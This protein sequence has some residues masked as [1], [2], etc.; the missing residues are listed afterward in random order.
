MSREKVYKIQ[1]RCYKKSNVNNSLSEDNKHIYSVI[2]KKAPA[3]EETLR[4]LLD[5]IGDE[6]KHPQQD[7]DLFNHIINKA[8]QHSL[9]H[10]SHLSRAEFFKAFLFT[11]TSE[12]TA[13][14]DVMVYTGGSGSCIAVWDPLLETISQFL[15]THKNSAIRAK[16]N[17]IEKELNQDSLLMIQH[18]LLSKIVKRSHLFYFGIP[19]FDESKTLTFK[20]AF[21]S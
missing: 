20:E 21:S 14:I 1:S 6:L 12:L 19:N 2:Y 13:V 3:V 15:I 16:P 11:V 4:Y 17:L 10:N 7:V 8:G 5:F 9:V 18:F